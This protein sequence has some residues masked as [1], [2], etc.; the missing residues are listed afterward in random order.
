M[1]EF[2]VD[3][4]FFVFEGKVCIFIFE[5]YNECVIVVELVGVFFVVVFDLYKDEI[6]GKNVVC[7]VSGGNN[8]IG[9]M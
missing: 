8:D 1:L 7:V 4:I 2:V 5:L 9:R 3:D 6:K